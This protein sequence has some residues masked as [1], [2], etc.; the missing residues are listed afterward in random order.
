MSELCTA[1]GVSRKTGYKW[2]KRYRDEGA[3]GLVERSR[4]PHRCANATPPE[5]VELVVSARQQHPRW[6]PR[7]L[8]A[9]LEPRHPDVRFPAAS[10]AGAI[11][12]RRGLV[13]PRRRRCRVPPYT[14][15]FAGC[16]APNDVWSADHKGSFLLGDRERC[17]PLTI[18]DMWSRFVLTCDALNSTDE[19]LARESF[20]EA[21]DTYGLPGTIRTDNGTP[22]ASPAPGG[23]SRLSVWWIRLGIKHERIAPGHPEQNGRHERMHRTLKYEATQPPAA[24]MAEQQLAF[25]VFRREFNHQRPHEA[26]GQKPPAM[27]Y[28]PSARPYTGQ[29]RDPEYPPGYETIRLYGKGQ[30]RIAGREVY[31]SLVLAN[32]VIGMRKLDD[33]TWLVRFA[34]VDLGLLR[35][36]E[37]NLRPIPGVPHSGAAK[38]RQAATPKRTARTE[39]G[40]E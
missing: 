20:E 10:T 17:Y 7:K 39:K 33:H 30:T 6:G 28:V 12:K 27:F 16:E 37:K 36:G 14:Q 22:F 31:I 3:D 15:P 34:D 5:V 18:A 19:R 38:R 4:A 25:D 40:G 23:L 35:E 13:K 1:F 29:E 9:W 21:F 11:L 2:L 32:Q 8:I 24:T 26:L